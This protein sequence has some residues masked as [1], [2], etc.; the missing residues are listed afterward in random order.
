M[1]TP[2]PTQGT[3]KLISPM[4][5]TFEAGSPMK[6]CRAEQKKRIPKEVLAARLLAALSDPCTSDLMLAAEA[7]AERA[8]VLFP[9]PN[10]LT[11]A[12]AEE[13]GE[14]IKAV[15]NLH[16][17]KGT[18]KDVDKEIVQCIAMCIR[19]WLEG[20]PSVNLKPVAGELK[21]DVMEI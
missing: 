18:V 21:K 7:E 10:H 1:N 19:L 20:D 12:L 13:A 4:G 2:Q 17:G 5:E 3:W 11:L 15:L 16:N 14:V 8:K 6:C 9:D